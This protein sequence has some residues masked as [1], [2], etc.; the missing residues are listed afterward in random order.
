M[1]SDILYVWL[2]NGVI[3]N[4]LIM[5]CSN[6]CIFTVK[7]QNADFRIGPVVSNGV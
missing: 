7:M 6:E 1:H 2:E 4:A 3:Y 5:K